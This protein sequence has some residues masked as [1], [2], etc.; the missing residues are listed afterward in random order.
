MIYEL[1][2]LPPGSPVPLRQPDLTALAD[3]LGGTPDTI[4]RRLV[5]LIG[6]SP[7][8]AARLRAMILL[9]SH[10]R[11]GPSRHTPGGPLRRARHTRRSVTRGGA[12]LRRPARHRPLRGSVTGRDAVTVR[13][14]ADR[15]RTVRGT[16]ERAGAVPG[17][18]VCR[19][20]RARAPTRRPVHVRARSPA[21]PSPADPFFGPIDP[22]ATAASTLRD[23]F[24]PPPVD[25]PL[26]PPPLPPPAR[27]AA[28]SPADPRGP[29]ATRSPR[30][31]T[32]RRRRAPEAARPIAAQGTPTGKP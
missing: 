13:G 18:P 10:F 2:N 12:V 31:S 19:R 21:G 11:S 20:T 6:A 16:T 27:C 15:L 26:S 24:G 4:E 28:A 30:A 25:D 29:G 32:S 8:E 3:A 9:R 23:P 5:E 14:T 1:R 17:R 22:L 7:E